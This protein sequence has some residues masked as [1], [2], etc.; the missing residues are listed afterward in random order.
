MTFWTTNQ[1]MRGGQPSKTGRADPDLTA[2]IERGRYLQAR[3]IH[4]AVHDVIA[5]LRQLIH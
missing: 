4:T 3:A 5:R 2:L 1:G